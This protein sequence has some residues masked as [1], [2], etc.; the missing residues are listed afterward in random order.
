M[1]ELP[2]KSWGNDAGSLK[3]PVKWLVLPPLPNL[4]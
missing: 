3:Y 2:M 1:L 4:S